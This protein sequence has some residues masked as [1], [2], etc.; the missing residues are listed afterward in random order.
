M[1]IER[2]EKAL[3]ANLT[4]FQNSGIMD[5]ADGSWGAAER[6]VITENN[7]A[8]EKIFYSFPAYS[9]YEKHAVI[10]HRR[11]DC[12]FQTALLFL[13]ASHYFDEKK[14]ADITDNILHY[15]HRRSGMRNTLFSE[16]PLNV[17][18][19]ANEKWIPAIYFDDNG[20]NC[21]LSIV[22]GRLS[23][24]LDK[25]YQLKNNALLLAGELH[26]GFIHHFRNQTA[27][28]KKTRW[29]GELE[30]PHWGSV[31]CMAFSYAYRETGHGAYRDTI[32]R[33]HDY[34]AANLEKFTTS[35]QAY[36]LLGS[37]IAAHFL[38]DRGVH[39]I[40]QRSADTLVTAQDPRTGNIPSE[41]EK[42]TPSGSHLV[43]TIYTNNWA[44]L[45]LNI[46]CTLE[47]DPK[48]YQAYDKLVTL[49]L[50][51]Q[52]QAPDRI[53]NGCWRG[54]YDLEK[55]TWG[56]G[57][58]FEG[59]ANSIYSG[60]TNAPISIV[61]ACILLDAG[62]TDLMNPLKGIAGSPRAE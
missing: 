56:G 37:S 13:L 26:S 44:V 45:G 21:I 43:D 49:L 57:D 25:K 12:N 28:E 8:L 39:E 52:D 34:L 59:G 58:R 18:R 17:W 51:I 6:I 16:Y 36:I 22:I 27:G 46:F 61:L 7:E 54:M 9:K 47:K 29:K 19:W 48:I 33:Y 20:W 41:W 1:H 35:E 14:Y 62:F 31:A 2:V 11:P 32:L 40:A 55:K 24:E 50:A 53:F 4:W 5:P 60:W 42:E 15:L 3:K 30:S 38:E 10:E 23:L